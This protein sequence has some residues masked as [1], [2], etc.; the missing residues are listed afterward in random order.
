MD[1]LEPE[2]AAKLSHLLALRDK[3]Y[4]KEFRS[5][6]S[7]I[8]GTLEGA[9]AAASLLLLPRSLTRAWQQLPTHAQ[10]LDPPLPP[11]STAPCRRWRAV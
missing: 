5:F 2:N 1:A 8:T 9:Q 11:L 3:L 4:S 6:I 7:D 10:R